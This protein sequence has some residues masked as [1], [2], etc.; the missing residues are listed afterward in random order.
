MNNK[1]NKKILGIDFGAK[2]IGIAVSDKNHNFAFPKVVLQN[3]KDLF[4]KIKEIIEKES[5][6]KIVIGESLNYKSEENLIM[7]E[8]KKFAERVKNK[9]N[10]E[11]IFEPEFLT[12]AQVR[13][14]QG[15]SKMID[16]S[17][18]ALILQSFLDKRGNE[19]Q[20]GFFSSSI[21][22]E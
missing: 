8:I 14:T 17:A 10:L 13:N 5:I 19:K 11:I 18:S 21:K 3:D 16:A 1:N 12:S 7:K 2:K 9:F 4:Q 22:E 6:G 20:R 15:D